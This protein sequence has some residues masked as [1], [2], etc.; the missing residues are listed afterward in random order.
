MLNREILIKGGT[1]IDGTGSPRVGADVMIREER[2]AD[3]GRLDSPDS[4]YVIDASGLTVSP[5]FIDAHTHAEFNIASEQSRMTMEPFI[6]Q[7]ITTM[8]TGSCG[9]SAAPLNRDCIEY[10]SSYWD[11]LLPEARLRWDWETVG[12]F[13]AQFDRGGSVLNIGQMVGHGSVRICTMGFSSRKPSAEE[14][15]RM[16]T[17]VRQ[18]LEEGAIGVSYGLTYVPG[19]WADT[20]ELIEVARDLPDFD[21]LISVHLRSQTV[22]FEQAVAEMIRVGETLGVP[23]QLSHYAPYRSEFVDPY[24]RT[25]EMTERARERGMRIGYDLLTPPV[26]STTICHL[27]P[28]W[29]F[30]NGFSAFLER[31]ADA[32]IRRRV[33]DELAREPVWPSWETNT[34]AENMCSYADPDGNPSWM[35][36]RLNGFRRPE[37]TKYEF[38]T[39]AS[40]ARDL[41]KDPFEALF[42]LTLDER[43]GLFFTGVGVDDDEVDKLAAALFQ[44]PHYSFMTDSVGIGRRA[45]AT[46]IYGTFPRFIGRHVRVWKTFTLEEAIRKCTSLPAQQHGFFDR[47][48]IRRGN[49][50]DLVIFDSAKVLDK[51]T[52]AKPYQYPEGIETVLINGVPVWHEGQLHTEKLSG[53][54]VRR[55]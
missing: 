36:F 32:G 26:S 6:R 14:L 42:D 39:V 37:H 27:F 4:A 19:I 10:L 8:V 34:L 40:I 49:R 25:F 7:G 48:V 12:E 9:V 29:M 33:V 18:S 23:L 41:G 53:R 1:V 24:L 21:G 43:G 50:A 54:V 35:E 28:P 2:I 52:F 15:A 16:R 22:F 5:G 51:A 46:T 44:L 47:G 17:I 13:L 20:D 3:V 30:E 45:R 38:E 11:C 31:L 55:S